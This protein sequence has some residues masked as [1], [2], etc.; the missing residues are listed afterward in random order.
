MAKNAKLKKNL[1]PWGS[2]GGPNAGLIKVA[3][4]KKPGSPGTGE[5]QC[6]I[7]PESG[8]NPYVADNVINLPENGGAFRIQFRLEG[9]DWNHNEPFYSS[10]AGCPDHK[11]N[12]DTQIFLQ[13]PN[14][15]FLTILNL[16]GGAACQIHYR[17]NFTGGIWCDPIL[18][19]GGNT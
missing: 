7:K 15:K 4:K 13:A 16:N 1:G 14:G 10:Q 11:T 3:V 8:S 9:L 12:D 2:P 17:M 5:I 6:T 19:N 18:N